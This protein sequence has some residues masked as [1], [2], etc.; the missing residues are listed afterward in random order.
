MI[1]QIKIAIWPTYAAGSWVPVNNQGLQNPGDGKTMR[2]WDQH[3]AA[4][5]LKPKGADASAARVSGSKWT[6]WTWG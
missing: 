4:E 5:R 2:G 3:K 6:K 1:Y